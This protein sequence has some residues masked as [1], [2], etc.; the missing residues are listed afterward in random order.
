MN[1]VP[2]DGGNRFSGSFFSAW[3]DKAWQGDNLSDEIVARGLA[4]RRRRR[5]DLRLQPAVGGPIK[6]DK[7]WFF[8]S[9]R[10]WSVDAPVPTSSWR[11]RAR[12]TAR[13]RQC[14][15]G[16]SSARPGSTTR[17]SR[18]RSCASPGRFSS[19]HK[20]AVYYDEINKARGH[21]MNAGDDHDTA[22]QIWTSPRYNSAAAKYTGTWS[23]QLLAEAGYSFN[24]EEYV[25]TNQDGVNKMAFTPEWYA[26]ASRRDQNLAR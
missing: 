4:Q 17:A 3:T 12:R 25:I 21:G 19:K 24:Y 8:A 13:H 16:A 5:P 14:R 6:R 11:R 7:L 18:A 15:S 23:N 26:N 2:K 22:S 10:M 20:F 9:G 1:I